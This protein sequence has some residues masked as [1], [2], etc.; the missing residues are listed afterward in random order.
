MPG[1]AERVNARLSFFWAPTPCGTRL[2]LSLATYRAARGHAARTRYARESLTG[3]AERLTR[4]AGVGTPP[5]WAA[6]LGSSRTRHS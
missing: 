2:V 6:S 1:R 5:R 3:A 4:R